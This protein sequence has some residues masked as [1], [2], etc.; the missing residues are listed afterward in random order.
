MPD[1]VV[2]V[3][4]SHPLVN[5]AAVVGIPDARLGAVPA[6]VIETKPGKDKPTVND[7]EHL[8]RKK[9]PATHVPV[10]SRLV[11]LLTRTSSTKARFAP[12]TRRSP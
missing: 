5:D 10:A 1:E 3:L 2:A 8:I 11:D 6:A 9:L 12:R 7:L 4:R